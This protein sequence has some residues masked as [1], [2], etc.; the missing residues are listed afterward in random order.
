MGCGASTEQ[1][2]R[3]NDY[4]RV[5]D[6]TSPRKVGA[7][8]KNS[9]KG[10]DTPDGSGSA[11]A[12]K[13]DAAQ[14]VGNQAPAAEPK[15]TTT[16][17]VMRFRKG[18]KYCD[19][20]ESSQPSSAREGKNANGEPLGNG[21]GSTTSPNQYGSNFGS[22]NSVSAFAAVSTEQAQLQPFIPTSNGVRQPLWELITGQ[23]DVQKQ[24]GAIPVAVYTDFGRVSLGV[25]REEAEEIENAEDALDIS[26]IITKRSMHTRV[27]RLN[28][29]LVRGHPKSI[30]VAVL[31]PNDWLLVST[32]ASIGSTESSARVTDIRQRVI[33]GSLDGR[34]RECFDS[35]VDASFT[36]DGSLLATVH[37][38]ESVLVW[39]MNTFRVKKTLVLNEDD[40]G[41]VRMVLVRIS[42]DSKL[43]AV[44]VEMFDDEGGTN[45]CVVVYEMNGG[46]KNGPLTRYYEPNSAICSIAFSPNCKTLASGT[47]EGKLVIWEARTATVL[48]EK[49]AHATPIRGLGYTPDGLRIITC[50]ERSIAAWD[51]ATL[52][53]IWTR[54][55][56]GECVPGV[57][58]KI[59]VLETSKKNPTSRAR[60]TCA[61]VAP[62]GLVVTA[63]TDRCVQFLKSSDGSE[64]TYLNMRSPVT[65]VSSGCRSIALGD[66]FGNLYIV[67][68]L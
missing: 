25:T 64:Y 58:P 63:K 18:V 26:A 52:T 53:P 59:L 7:K 29:R 12:Q 40:L 49:D 24:P 56:S 48:I 60:H 50:D 34:R 23:R 32:D 66:L 17:L 44:G 43:V 46:A 27:K 47:H 36:V 65:K 14:G 13:G 39:D 4:K 54:L 9:G 68:L 15:Y 30:R 67:D 42:P 6:D 8:G 31:S 45:G 57:A 61:T 11:H 3:E 28:V 62:G 10:K 35:A 55:P 41:E 19:L 20:P 22:S 21:H 51:S 2:S 37:R 5:S 16:N 33:C 38:M 1:T